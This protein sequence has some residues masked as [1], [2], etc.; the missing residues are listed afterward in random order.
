MIKIS[1]R[2]IGMASAFALLAGLA[3][4]QD[5]NGYVHSDYSGAQGMFV[6]PASIA[7][8]RYLVD[9]NLLSFGFN[10]YNNAVGVSPKIITQPSIVNDENFDEKYMVYRL[11]GGNKSGVLSA[12]IYGPSATIMLNQYMAV[13]LSSRMRMGVSFNN[14]SNELVDLARNGFDEQSLFNTQLNEKNARISS[15]LWA[16]YGLTWG[17]VVKA[18]GKHFAKV[19]ATVKVLQGFSSAYLYMD[20]V[21]Y[22]F[23][24]K[25]TLSF[26]NA[27]F[28]YGHAETFDWDNPS[29]NYDFIA[30]PSVGFDLGAVYE[31]RPNVPDGEFQDPSDIKKYKLR[32]GFSILDIGRLRYDKYQ[33]NDFLANENDV[34]LSDFEAGSIQELDSILNARFGFQ[35]NETK[36]KVNLPT[37]INL[38]VDWN[39]ASRLY[40]NASA[41]MAINPRKNQSYLNATSIYSVTPRYEGKLWGIYLPQTINRFGKYYSGVTLRFGPFIVGSNTIVSQLIQKNETYGF[42]VH[43][44]FR[45]PILYAWRKVEKTAP[46]VVLDK[47]G[48]GLK[49]TDDACPEIAGPIDNKGCP[50]P[51]RDAD[52]TLDK[53]DNCP[54][55]AG[56]KDL[57][58][59]PDRDDDMVRDMDDRCPDV[60]GLKDLQGCPDAD[61]DGVADMDDQCPEKPGDK[62]HAGC[63]DTDG[64]GIFDNEDACIDVKG[65]VENKGCPYADKDGDGIKDTEDACP[66]QAGPMENKGCPWSDIDGDGVFDKDDECPKTPGPA[67]NKGCPVIEKKEQEVLD[68]AFQNLEFETGKSII[69]T[70]SYE[71]LNRLAD[72]LVRKPSYKLHISGHTDNVGNDASNMTLSKNRSLAVKKYLADKGVNVDRLIADWFGETKPI[73]TNATPEGRQRNRR[74]EMKVEFD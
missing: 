60:A 35:N 18:K 31:W 28:G 19:G 67:D 55:V 64:D 50:W 32:A 20:D 54:D 51:D 63:P 8:S 5:F 40:L 25:D 41:Y 39:I 68:L 6:Q 16:E 11:S 36:Y 1:T 2:I 21:T 56:K 66:D 22:N 10:V 57:Q 47:D 42:D 26:F 3:K 52:G 37:A 69:R 48:D 4:A 33:S 13:G 30:K 17:Q 65:L 43:A 38:M 70:T 7:D 15:H 58:G 62:A 45:I 53:D 72:L 59:C 14:V 24:N 74:V 12:N 44:G 46:P 49:D 23:K 71:S 61:L 9:I 29:F 34:P 73:D 27:Q